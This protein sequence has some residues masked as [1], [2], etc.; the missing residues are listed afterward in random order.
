MDP[1][2][3]EET[4]IRETFWQMKFIE[5]FYARVS[6]KNYPNNCHTDTEMTRFFEKLSTLFWLAPAFVGAIY[7]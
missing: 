1:T 3:L 4:S 2:G 6:L 7:F 5:N